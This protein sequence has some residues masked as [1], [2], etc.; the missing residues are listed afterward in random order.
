VPPEIALH[1]RVAR[2]EERVLGLLED[3]VAIRR[4]IGDTRQSGSI[5]HRLHAVEDDASA[6][7][8]AAAALERATA[9][10]EAAERARR[11]RGGFRIARWQFVVG[12]LI[13]LQVLFLPWLNLILNLLHRRP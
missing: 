10:H 7:R 6:A 11:E 13:A 4:E 2:L 8:I 1:E 5:R 9:E 12:L 3:V